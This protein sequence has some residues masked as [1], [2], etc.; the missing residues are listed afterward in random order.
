VC[1]CVCVCVCVRERERERER[2]PCGFLKPQPSTTFLPVT[3]FLQQGHIFQ[4]FLKAAS[5]SRDQAFKHMSLLGLFSFRQPY[6]AS[7]IIYPWLA[8]NSHRCTSWLCFLSARIEGVCLH[9]LPTPF[10]L[11][12]LEVRDD[13][14]YFTIFLFLYLIKSRWF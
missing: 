8:L 14:I 11:T 7:L 3:H 9:A 10:N 1:V 13:F 6:R 5:P 4:S 2:T 12:L